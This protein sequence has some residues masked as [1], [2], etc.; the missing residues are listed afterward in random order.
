MDCYGITGSVQQSNKLGMCPCGNQWFYYY[1]LFFIFPYK[2][3]PDQA[4]AKNIVKIFKMHCS[5]EGNG[6]QCDQI[7]RNFA[8]VSKLGKSLVIFE[9]LF[10]KVETYFGKKYAFW[11]NLK[12]N[13]AIWSH[14]RYATLA[15]K[16]YNF[17]HGQSPGHTLAASYRRSRQRRGPCCRSGR[18]GLTSS[19]GRRRSWPTPGRSNSSK[20]RR[21][22][23]AR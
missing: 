10:T 20:I 15:H 19:S 11:P 4:S 7:W 17:R 12:P 22:W 2:R 6:R 21:K 13:L 9:G 16:I 1:I 18:S 14:W 23:A 3:V 8:T 5:I